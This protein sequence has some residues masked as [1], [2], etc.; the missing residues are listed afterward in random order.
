MNLLVR[1]LRYLYFQC[2]FASEVAGD[3]R[4]SSLIASCRLLMAALGITIPLSSSE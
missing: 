2:H 4:R 1:L 3:F